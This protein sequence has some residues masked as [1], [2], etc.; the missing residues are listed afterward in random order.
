MAEEKDLGN[1]EVFSNDGPVLGINSLGRI[2]KLSLWHH[3]GR[4]YFKRIIVNQGREIGTG[5]DAAAQFIEKDSTYGL[6]H[7]FLHGNRHERVIEIVDEEKGEMRI[8][9]IPVIILREKRNP[10]DIPWREHDAR[11]VI[12][13]TG[14]FKDPTVPTNDPKGSIRGHLAGG[15]QK[16][17]NSA[18][19]KI[20]DK[21][22]KGRY[23]ASLKVHLDCKGQELIEIP[24]SLMLFQ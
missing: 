21:S 15:A 13:C 1:I 22:L 20:K 18:P 7:H 17:L 2:G 14:Q 16:V 24:V 23:Y 3:V 8:D 6:L 9:G 19:F 4:K 5:L 12:D 11:L 10:K